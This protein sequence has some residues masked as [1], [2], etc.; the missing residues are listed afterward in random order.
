M[1]DSR[2]TDAS[3][4]LEYVPTHL[5]VDGHDFHVLEVS[6]TR[7]IVIG[8]ERLARLRDGDPSSEVDAS[9]LEICKR[10]SPAVDAVVF[11]ADAGPGRRWRF[12]D[13]LDASEVAQLGEAMVEGQLSLYRGLVH[14][15]IFSLTGIALHEREHEAFARGTERVAARIERELPDAAPDRAPILR[16]DLWLLDHLALWTNTARDRFFAGRLPEIL[17]LIARRRRQLQLMNTDILESGVHGTG[18]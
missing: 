7:P 17:S 11:V 5:T 15:G 16:L 14:A 12:A 1:T 8:R 9:M 3:S 6:P 18:G 13:E 4:G 2:V 10:W